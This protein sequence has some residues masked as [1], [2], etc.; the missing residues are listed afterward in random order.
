MEQVHSCIVT[1]DLQVLHILNSRQ[2]REWHNARIQILILW[3][4]NPKQGRFLS[5][6]AQL[7]Y[8]G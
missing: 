2:G 3:I 4:A 1:R 7:Q 8:F 6:L 5:M